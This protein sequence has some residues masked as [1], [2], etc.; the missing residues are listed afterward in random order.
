MSVSASKNTSLS[1]VVLVVVVVRVL[2]VVVVRVLVV[3]VLV[4]CVLVRV[5][6]LLDVV[7]N[8]LV[9]EPCVLVLV[10]VNVVVLDTVLVDVLVVV[11]FVEAQPCGAPL[12]AEAIVSCPVRLPI[13]VASHFGARMEESEPC[14]SFRT[15]GLGG[16]LVP[17]AGFGTTGPNSMTAL[18]ASWSL[19]PPIK[20]RD[21]LTR[22]PPKLQNMWSIP[23]MEWLLTA[24]RRCFWSSCTVCDARSALKSPRRRM[25]S[26]A[27][28]RDPITRSRLCAVETPPQTPPEPTGRG[29]WWLTSSRFLLVPRCCSL[30]HC[31]PRLP[32]Y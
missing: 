26:P 30:I 17:E 18:S 15:V 14:S 32:V 20:I 22:A 24:S 29:P 12:D 28:A 21:D 7:V 23:L 13:C 25:T 2:V 3:R 16:G 1:R 8:V 9:V 11:V 19:P 5:V 6:V 4:V 31:A 10:D 27:T